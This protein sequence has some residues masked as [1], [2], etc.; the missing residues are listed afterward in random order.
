VAE[1][2]CLPEGL[3]DAKD[4]AHKSSMETIKKRFDFLAIKKHGESVKTRTVVILCA[5]S[6]KNCV[7]FTASRR[8][9][10]AVSRNKAK[11]RLRH[12]VR[13]HES[14]MLGNFS[15][16]CIANVRTVS[17]SFDVLCKDFQY[18]ITKSMNLVKKH[19]VLDN[20]NKAISSCH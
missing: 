15:F 16:V 13:K 8:V 9:G 4:F 3:K 6:A 11:R 7:G 19:C 17:E 12:L 5:Q 18:A 2:S 20:S 10:N 1:E 14:A